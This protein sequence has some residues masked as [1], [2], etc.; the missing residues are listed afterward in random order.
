MR[1]LKLG[2][3]FSG[4]GAFELAGVL[5]GITPVWASEVE[6]FCIRVTK[7]RFPDMVHLGSV[8]DVNGSDSAIYKMDGNAIAVPCGVYVL[9]KIADELRK[10]GKGIR[11]LLR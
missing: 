7:L 4:S 5:N 11:W 2:S 6:P 9:G 3:L 8:T 1:E 10:R